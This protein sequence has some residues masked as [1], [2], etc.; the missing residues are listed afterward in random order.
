M[1]NSHEVLKD[2]ISIRGAKAVAAEMGLSQS[3]IY[4]WCQPSERPDDSGADNPLDRVIGLYS[5]TEE[6]EPIEWL[7]EQ[8]DSFRVRNPQAEPCLI[9]SLV[10]ENTQVMLKEYSEVLEAVMESYA[11]K[12]HIDL[13]G[14]KRIRKE[15]EDLKRAGEQFVF[16]CEQGIFNSSEKG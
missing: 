9:S 7:C 11:D 10:L 14:A 6:A 1:K 8:T 2:V 3:M 13:D 16:G 4:K 5:I 15:W 12:N